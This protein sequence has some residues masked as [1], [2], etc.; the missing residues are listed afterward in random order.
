MGKNNFES[1]PGENVPAKR[2]YMLPA[3]I[4]AAGIMV[5]GSIIYLVGSKNVPQAPVAVGDQGGEQAVVAGE[6]MKIGGRD[7]ILGEENAPVT[8]IEYGD[9][10]CPFCARFHSDV[11]ARLRDEYIKTGKV[12][13]VFRNF[14]FLGP[15]SVAAGVAAECA[16]DQG[17]FWAFHD[18]I[19]DEELRDGQEHNSNLNKDLFLSIAGD[20]GMNTGDFTECVD[21][22]K[23][24]AQIAED[25]NA[26]A[27]AGV[28]ST[29][30]T[31]INGQKIQGALPYES[32]KQ[33]IDGLL[34][35]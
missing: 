4:L 19:Y 23:Y 13:M 7:V 31:F 11:S 15:E 5:S 12:R 25:R 2:D 24:D 1:V 14:Q 28:N 33:V 35:S 9:F 10:Q 29:P 21:G 26:A 8:L 30:I 32:F 20:L 22:G 3:S 17:K 34:G 27:A 18:A 6:V 16:K